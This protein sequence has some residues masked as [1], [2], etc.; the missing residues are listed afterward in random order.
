MIWKILVSPLMLFT[1]NPVSNLMQVFK[2]TEDDTT[3]VTSDYD[4][5]A[6][7][8]ETAPALI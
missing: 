8:H 7:E 5:E 1:C 6:S 3:D 2:P 4:G